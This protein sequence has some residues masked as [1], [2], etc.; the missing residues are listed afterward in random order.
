MY[1]DKRYDDLTAAVK[2]AVG[3]IADCY[4]TS[5]VYNNNKGLKTAA[6]C[7]LIYNSW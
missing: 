2:K 7:K 3:S 4:V 5:N 1:I 6:R